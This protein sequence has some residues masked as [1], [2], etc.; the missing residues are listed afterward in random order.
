MVAT[1]FTD[2][3]VLSFQLNA[4]SLNGLVDSNP[5][6]LSADD[7]LWTFKAKFWSLKVQVL[8]IPYESN[9]LDMEGELNGLKLAMNKM[10][11]SYKR[12]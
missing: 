4:T 9:K 10:V 6:S 12:G 5:K 3:E 2:C 11:E 1:D 8:H 7:I